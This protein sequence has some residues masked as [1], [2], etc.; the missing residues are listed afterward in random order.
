M[1]SPSNDRTKSPMAIAALHRLVSLSGTRVARLGKNTNRP[2]SQK[3]PNC[4]T[5][6]LCRLCNLKPETPQTTRRPLLSCRV[7][8]VL[9]SSPWREGADGITIFQFRVSVKLLLPSVS[10]QPQTCTEHHFPSLLRTPQ[11]C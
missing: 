7:G 11:K 9:I 10:L 2:P 6:I 1:D 8:Q 4:Q 5:I 3:N